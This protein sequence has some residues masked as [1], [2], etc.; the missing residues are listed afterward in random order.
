MDLQDQ[1]Y[2]PSQ[3]PY[4]PDELWLEI[5]TQIPWSTL[6]FTLRAV[7]PKFRT[8]IEKQAITTL[9]PKFTVALTYTLGSGVRHRWYDV[10]ATIT[11][12]F[13]SMNK[14]NPGFALFRLSTVHPPN[15]H[16]RALEKWRGM[17]ARDLCPAGLDWQLSC[18][19]ATRKANL[20][21]V[22]AA[23]EAALWCDWKEVL[24]RWFRREV[25]IDAKAEREG[26]DEMR[27]GTG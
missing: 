5:L 27:L 20:E 15:F 25:E 16:D 3:L 14:H 17:C 23:E 21:K 2:A 18:E 8:E 19:G 1:K 26:R 10:R 24:D 22:V 12:S 6:W 9:L 4:L 11:L 7:H 13:V